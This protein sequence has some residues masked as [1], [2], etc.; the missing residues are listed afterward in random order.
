[1]IID[2]HSGTYA[3]HEGSIVFATVL[4]LECIVLSNERFKALPWL[5]ARPKS[6]RGPMFRAMNAQ[7]ITLMQKN[8]GDAIQDGCA[9]ANLQSCVCRGDL[10]LLT[11]AKASSI[12]G[13][14]AN[15]W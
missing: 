8:E 4:L 2:V 13:T 14:Q 10:V 12:V 7:R 5:D 1:M 6:F 15:R 9:F 3:M 11:I